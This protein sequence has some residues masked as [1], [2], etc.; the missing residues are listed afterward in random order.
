[1]PKRTV[2]YPDRSH[3]QK[4]HARAIAV[5]S[6]LAAPFTKLRMPKPKLTEV[7]AVAPVALPHEHLTERPPV[8]SIGRVVAHS[9]CTEDDNGVLVD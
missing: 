5:Q 1:M 6:F 9:R 7:P 3:Q 4:M 2:F 8:D